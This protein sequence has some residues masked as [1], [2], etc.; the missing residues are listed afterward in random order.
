MSTT[1]RRCWPFIVFGEFR[2]SATPVMKML[3][4][5]TKSFIEAK[6]SNDVNFHRVYRYFSDCIILY[7]P[8]VSPAGSCR[9][10]LTCAEL[11]RDNC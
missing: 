11:E 4:E 3:K 6:M 1:Q 2:C 5:V 7:V 9:C 10:H 8:F